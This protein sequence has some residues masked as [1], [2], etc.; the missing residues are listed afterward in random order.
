MENF[1]EHTL[2]EIERFGL[3]AS[4]NLADGHSYMDARRLFPDVIMG[5]SSIWQD[6]AATSVPEME[7]RFA[8]AFAEFYDVPGL[9]NRKSFSICPTASN[10]IDIFGAWACERNLKVALV[11]PTFDNLAL[12]LRR[13]GVNLVSVEEALVYNDKSLFE[14]R[15]FLESNNIDVLFVVHPNNPT[16]ASLAAAAFEKLAKTCAQLK[17]ILAVDACFRF[18]NSHSMDE[19]SI[20]QKAG[21]SYVLIED[22][23]KLWPTLD[24]KASLLSAS[25]DIEKEIRTIF[26]EIY[27]CSSNFTLA[28]IMAFMASAASRGGL[29]FMQNIVRERRE[30]AESSLAGYVASSKN[31]ATTE[32]MSVMWLDISS[33]GLTDLEIVQWL[34]AES[35]SVLPGRYFYW[36]SHETAGHNY[37]RVSLLKDDRRFFETIDKLSEIL[38]RDFSKECVN[39]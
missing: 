21:V 14:L 31:Y 28:V 7:R 34:A 17:V 36:N 38:E 30:Y 23:G 26:E 1:T 22:T 25:E 20:L 13:R 29:R 35:I 10:S 27:L 39:G 4:G 24:A 19:Y 9:L 33:T 16:A 15:A 3:S 12:I 37:V 18:C 8:Q 32:L 11:E 2:T 6:A 5:L